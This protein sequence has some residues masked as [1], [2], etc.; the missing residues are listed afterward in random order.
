MYVNLLDLTSSSHSHPEKP[1][2]STY[3]TEYQLIS[4]LIELS[5]PVSTG[6]DIKFAYA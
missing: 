1:Q 5:C 2:N 3:T 4:A 6:H